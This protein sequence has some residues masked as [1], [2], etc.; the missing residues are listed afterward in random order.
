MT[1]E[2]LMGLITVSTSIGALFGLIPL[3]MGYHLKVKDLGWFGFFMCIGTSFLWG[4]E[5]SLIFAVIIGTIIYYEY[6][7]YKKQS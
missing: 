2:E 6:T 1:A 5:V 3:L 7:K 4:W